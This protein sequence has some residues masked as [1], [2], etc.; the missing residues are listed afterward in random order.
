MSQ[1]SKKPD[2]NTVVAPE[3]L[4]VSSTC[5]IS[6]APEVVHLKITRHIVPDVLENHHCGHGGWAQSSWGSLL[7][8]LSDTRDTDST[9]LSI[10]SVLEPFPKF[11]RSYLYFLLLSS[12]AY[13]LSYILNSPSYLLI[14][15]EF[16]PSLK[17]QF[18]TCL[19]MQM[20]FI[21]ADSSD[22]FYL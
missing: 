10:G 3:N 8:W 13:I 22:L 15:S 9:P 7:P 16:F 18:K 6:N 19:F 2:T 11:L 20:V 12:F 4:K 14:I 21:S 5:V 17:A 1:F